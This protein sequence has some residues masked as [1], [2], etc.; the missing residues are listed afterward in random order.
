MLEVPAYQ[1]IGFAHGGYRDMQTIIVKLG[2]QDAMR[3][4][5]IGQF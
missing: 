3:L 5:S 4:I 2:G 1:H